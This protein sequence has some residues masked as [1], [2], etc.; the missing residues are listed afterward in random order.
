MIAANSTGIVAVLKP[1]GDP[2]QPWTL[3][4]IDRLP[5]SHRIR[6]ADLSGTGH[7]VA[8]NAPLIGANAV[9]PEYRDR[10]PLVFY[11]PGEWKR[12]ELRNENEGVVHGITIVRWD[13]EKRDSILTASFGGI[14]L[15]SAGKDVWNHSKI[16]KGN[17][18]PWPKG[19]T[20]DIA[21]GHLGKQRFLAA[22]EPWHGN[23]V[24]VYTE[25]KGQWQREVIDTTLVDA[26]TITTADLNSNGHDQIVAGMRGKPYQVLIYSKKKGGWTRQVLDT[27]TMAAASCAAAD[28]N[29][30][31]RIDLACIGSATTNLKWYENL[32]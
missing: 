11:T 24:V 3:T 6:W 16:S 8:I 25:H 28:F 19:G 10:V 4:E 31:H 13:G 30:D 20:S 5:T 2:R 29:G 18:E 14:D 32:K 21:V 26:H 1:N 15:Y 23:K 7:K 9:A 12:R 17:P 27:G 22:I